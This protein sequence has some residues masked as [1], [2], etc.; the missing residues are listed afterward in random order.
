MF[1]AD[2]VVT[3]DIQGFAVTDDIYGSQ[4]RQKP[5]VCVCLL[6]PLPK[7]T[8]SHFGVSL[9]TELSMVFRVKVDLSERVSPLLELTHSCYFSF[10]RRSL[11]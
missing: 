10:L 4:W 3:G 5:C 6:V 2:R 1:C 8:A 7:L 9:Q 11:L